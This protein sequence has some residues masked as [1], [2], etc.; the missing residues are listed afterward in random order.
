MREWQAWEFMSVSHM[1]ESLYLLHFLVLIRMQSQ[2]AWHGEKLE[3]VKSGMFRIFQLI[4]RM[5]DVLMIQMLFVLT[6]S[7]ERAAYAMYCALTLVWV[8]QKICARRLAI[9][10]R[11]FLIR[12]IRN[13]HRQLFIRFLKITML[14]VSQ[15]SRSASVISVRKMELWQMQ[16]FSMAR[17]HK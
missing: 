3:R 10:L 1:Q 16:Q 9:L 12:R 4:R 6:V 13:W 11:I 15:F 2:R 8:F 14:P 5:W 7:L 17:I